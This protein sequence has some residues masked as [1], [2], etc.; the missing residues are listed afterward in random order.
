MNHVL[1][2][3]IPVVVSSS[4]LYL[5]VSSL[6]LSGYFRIAVADPFS[7]LFYLGILLSACSIV[8]LSQMRHVYTGILQIVLVCLLLTMTGLMTVMYGLEIILN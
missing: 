7:L 5:I 8:L 2:R 1:R 6:V 3:S 4:I